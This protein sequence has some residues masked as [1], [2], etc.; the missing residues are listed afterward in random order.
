[1]NFSLLKDTQNLSG[2]P[3]LAVIGLDACVINTQIPF[4]SSYLQ[5][6]QGLPGCSDTLLSTQKLTKA[7]GSRNF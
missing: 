5:L 6:H 3:V 4:M 1:M 7:V 2:Q